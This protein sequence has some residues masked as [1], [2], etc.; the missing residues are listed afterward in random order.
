MAL[1]AARIFLSEWFHARLD[2]PA[3]ANVARALARTVKPER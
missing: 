3:R 1:G 2:V